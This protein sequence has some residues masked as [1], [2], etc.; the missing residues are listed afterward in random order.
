MTSIIFP[1][2]GLAVGIMLLRHL[3]KNRSLRDDLECCPRC[4]SLDVSYLQKAYGIGVFAPATN[5]ECR[6]CGYHGFPIIF[7]T[8]EDYQGFLEEIEGDEERENK[9]D[10]QPMWGLF[11]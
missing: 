5:V 1:V 9:M 8:A 3:L 6:N 2:F 7:E 10:G 11:D 4:G